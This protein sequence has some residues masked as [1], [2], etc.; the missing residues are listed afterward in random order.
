MEKELICGMKCAQTI[1][2]VQSFNKD[3]QTFKFKSR[4]GNKT[5]G[6]FNAS[7]LHI[8]SLS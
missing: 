2:L 7:Y 6:K 5:G 1:E 8:W 4:G 3:G